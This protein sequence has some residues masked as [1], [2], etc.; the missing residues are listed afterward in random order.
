MNSDRSQTN[1]ELSPEKIKALWGRVNDQ[2]IPG[3][4]SVS[5]TV[6]RALLVM[7][8]RVPVLKGDLETTRRLLNEAED[9][10]GL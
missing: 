4:V 2:D 9:R 3:N 7:A 6:L 8:E 1:G 5:Q 10:S